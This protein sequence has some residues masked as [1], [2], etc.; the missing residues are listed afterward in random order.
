MAEGCEVALGAARVRGAVEH[1]ADGDVDDFRGI[2][3]GRA[4][5][6]L[7][8]EL[9][10]VTGVVSALGPAYEAPQA[11]LPALAPRDETRCLNLTIWRPAQR[12]DD[13]LPV[14][15]W[16][17][18][19]AH[20]L[21][22]SSGPLTD[23]GRLA[24]RERLVVVAVNYRL[25]VLGHV[26]LADALG[27]AYAE[28]GNLA[29]LDQRLALEWVHSNIRRFGGDPGRVTIMGESSGGTDVMMHL[30]TDA[31]GVLFH[32]AI[33]QSCTLE[34]ASEIEAAIAVRQELLAELGFADAAQLLDVP[35]PTL[36]AAQDRLV[37][38]R[39]AGRPSGAIPFHPIIDGR[40]VTHSRF[41]DIARGA[42]R[43][44]PLM[45]GTNR[46]ESSGWIDIRPGAEQEVAASDLTR[47]VDGN[48]AALAAGYLA[49]RGFA[50]GRQHLIEAVLTELLYRRATY[51]A[52]AARSGTS[53]FASLFDWGRSDVGEWPAGAHHALDVPFTFRHLDD[54]AD[55][56]AAVGPDAPWSLA[57]R[58]SA[59][60]GS[61][62]HTGAPTSE[63][64]W[65]PY[66][67]QT[68]EV[69]VWA[70][71]PRIERAPDRE[72]RRLVAAWPYRYEVR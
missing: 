25:G 4:Q 5:R 6:F 48:V 59:A 55:A 7:P 33:A 41:A 21:G 17:H 62:A 39:S 43:E 31:A 68:P 24:A 3:Y 27:A 1:T 46:N 72:V 63:A 61:F 9:V 8:A 37:Q 20:M 67:P 45:L 40:T 47:F 32:G 50:P 30:A 64:Q 28:S 34:R 52:L 2:E 35:A 13:P 58:M 42:A 51:R 44:V 70:M 15:F 65:H 71:E 36:I 56:H 16:I 54:S 53:T 18:G 11:M 29:L 23:G 14:L 49:D 19:G 66:T 10:E 60:L 26:W 69:M 57:D 22:S 38:A 12:H